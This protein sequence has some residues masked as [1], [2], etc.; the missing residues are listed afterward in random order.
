MTYKLCEKALFGAVVYQKYYFKSNFHP[1]NDN[2]YRKERENLEENE[3]MYIFT[4]Y[5]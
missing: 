4:A 2:K 1:M 3:N 5:K